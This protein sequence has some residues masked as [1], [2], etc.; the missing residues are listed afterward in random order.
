MFKISKFTFATMSRFYLLLILIT[1][2]YYC[3]DTD[4]SNS[5]IDNGID[6]NF[7]EIIS[8]V[9]EDDDIHETTSTTIIEQDENRTLSWFENCTQS[10]ANLT[11]PGP[12]PASSSNGGNMTRQIFSRIFDYYKVIMFT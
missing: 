3:Q 7:T 2:Q 10:C 8:D 6:Q 12:A 11:D 1:N 9:S 5:E 4:L